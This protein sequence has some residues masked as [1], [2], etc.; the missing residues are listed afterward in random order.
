MPETGVLLVLLGILLF[1]MYLF[2]VQ[3][4]DRFMHL[5]IEDVMRCDTAAPSNLGP[6]VSC[7]ASARGVRRFMIGVPLAD[8]V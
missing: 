5:F 3:F 1:I 6:G 4:I 7:S 2:P 8:L